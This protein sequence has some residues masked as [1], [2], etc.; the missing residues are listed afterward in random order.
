MGCQLQ[1]ENHPIPGKAERSVRVCRAWAVML[2]AFH[3]HSG[4]L[5]TNSSENASQQMDNNVCQ[6]SEQ[7]VGTPE[8]VITQ[9]QVT[10]LKNIGAY[11]I[12]THG[13]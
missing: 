10:P 6:F 1:C 7:R 11:V 12:Y 13:N 2:I 9:S 5:G 4:G 8:S 3:G